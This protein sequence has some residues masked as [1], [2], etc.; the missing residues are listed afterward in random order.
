MR[1][2][3]RNSFLA[4]TVSAVMMGAF[5]AI[6]GAAPAIPLNNG[7]ETT[8]AKFGG[9]GSFSYTIEGTEFCYT[10]TYRKLTMAPW[11][12]HVH[13]VAGRHADAGVV[14]PLAVASGASGTT[15]DCVTIDAGL[16]AAIEAN[17]GNYY[18]N[19]HTDTFPGGEIRG[20]LK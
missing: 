8:D 7:Q 4:F 10:L 2:A 12:A 1:R 5:A 15:S 14:I 20:Q 9:S 6:A 16:A 17:P 19:V 13:G 11:G 18:V 3:S